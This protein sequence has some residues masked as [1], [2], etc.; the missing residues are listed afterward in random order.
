MDSISDCIPMSPC[1]IPVNLRL[2]SH[3][4][5]FDANFLMLEFSH[6]DP[7]EITYPILESFGWVPPMSCHPDSGM[8]IGG[9]NL[10]FWRDFMGT[11]IHT[12]W[13]PLKSRRERFRGFY[14]I[15]I[16]GLIFWFSE[17]ENRIP[18]M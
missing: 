7:T 10:A 14:A 6:T 16:F 5:L 15:F 9:Q 13:V 8:S 4:S 12:T 2:H 11:P 1:S 18:I 17:S 3:E